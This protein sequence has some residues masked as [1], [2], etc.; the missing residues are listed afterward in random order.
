MTEAFICDAIRTPFGRRAGG[1]SAVRTDDLAAVPIRYLVDKYPNI[2]WHE[3]DDLRYGC[4]NQAGE[5]NRNVARWATLLAGLPETVPAATVSRLCGSGMQAVADAARCI[6]LGDGEFMIAGG[7]EGMSRAPYVIGKA[8]NG[9]DIGQVMYDTTIAMRFP[10]KIMVDRECLVANPITAENV[11]RE[12]NVSREDQDKFA[13]WSQQK[14]KVAQEQGLLAE[15]IC[16]VTVRQKKGSVIVSQDEHLRPETTLEI[17]AGLKAITGPDGTVTAG[18]SSGINDGACALLLASE[19]KA[20][21]L[22]LTP[23]VRVLGC[24]VAGVPPRIM[25]IGPI[26]ATRKILEQ[27]HMTIDQMDVIEIN[28][29]F[30]SQVVACMRALGIREDDPRVNALGGAIALGHPLGASGARLVTTA[31]YQLC[32]TG[33][34]YALCTMCIGAGQGIAMVL[35]RV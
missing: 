10:N 8:Q 4:V 1:L 27:L 15:E 3:V 20:A 23:K 28:E 22:G 17:L 7:V 14:A 12:F 30:A 26:P 32:R 16:P 21:Q 5:D 31:T 19:R 29:A 11:A 18:N 13:Y 2:D 6:L 9:Y 24:A 33:G 34:R 35:E 25:G